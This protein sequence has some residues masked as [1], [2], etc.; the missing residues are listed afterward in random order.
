VAELANALRRA[1]ANLKESKR[2]IGNFLFLGPTGVGKTET[3]KQLAKVYFGSEKNMIRLNMSEY[4][5]IE[6]MEKLIG[7]AAG[8]GVL[9]AAVRD[10]PFSMILIDEIEK[11]HSGLLNIFLNI[12]DE[13]EMND[14]MGRTIDFKHTIIIATSNAGADYIKEAVDRGSSLANFKDTFIDNILRKTF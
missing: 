11:A 13:G 4:Q 10:N 7:G 2:T 5:T 9:S 6:S 12:F 14:G 3:A 1:H 8:P